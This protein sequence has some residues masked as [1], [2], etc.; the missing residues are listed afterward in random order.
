M[1]L[2]YRRRCIEVEIHQIWKCGNNRRDILVGRLCTGF[3]FVRSKTLDPVE[4][5]VL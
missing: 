3:C 1:K 2:K 4:M 5:P